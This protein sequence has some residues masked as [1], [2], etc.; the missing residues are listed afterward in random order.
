MADPI[1]L[2]L[3]EDA[4]RTSLVRALRARQID[5]LT[6]N[7]AEKVGL[8]DAAQLAFAISQNRAIFT[9][10]RGDFVQLHTE[11]LH[12]NRT[13]SGIIVS[14]QLEIGVVIR[15]LLKL[16]DARLLLDQPHVGH[17]VRIN[18]VAVV[19]RLQVDLHPVDGAVELVAAG[20]VLICGRC[21]GIRADVQRFIERYQVGDRT[22]GAPFAYLLALDE[23]QQVSP[24]ADATTVI[25]ELDTNLALA[26]FKRLLR[27]SVG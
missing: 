4:Q 7:E 13:H 20:W 18:H 11:F 8:S 21:P 22:L 17:M 9:F 6:A 10:N 12:Q 16:L 26:R 3:D 27:F 19:I 5:V 1:H 24:F 25:L 23:K 2:Y 15:R 14:D